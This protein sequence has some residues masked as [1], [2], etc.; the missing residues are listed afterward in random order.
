M[1]RILFVAMLP[2][3]AIAN[4]K[5]VSVVG[6]KDFNYITAEYSSTGKITCDYDI[7]EE[8]LYKGQSATQTGTNCKE[9]FTS[10]Y[11]TQ[12]K[13]YP[14]QTATITGTHLESSCK[15]I[16]DFDSLLPSSNYL[17]L[18][19]GTEKTVTCD[20]TIDNGGWTLVQDVEY[21]KSGIAPFTALDDKGMNYTE[22]L[23]VDEGS[24]LDYNTLNDGNWYV[25]GMDMFKHLIKVNGVWYNKAG[26]PQTCLTNANKL[27]ETSYRVIENNVTY[28]QNGATNT[29]SNCGSK[30]V[31]T[32]P[33]GGKLEGFHDIESTYSSCYT[34]NTINANYKLYLR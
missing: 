30:I 12:Y 14:D 21:Y 8:M 20:M 17:I 33:V 28:C 23:Y 5:Y 4:N 1:K 25:Q 34:D 2:I 6:E 9:E 16:H 10:K 13:D 26:G 3:C 29:P 18:V 22:F 24:W 27:P 31:V 7:T 32:L 19:S 11:G 15:G